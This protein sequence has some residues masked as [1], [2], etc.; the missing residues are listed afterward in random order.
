MSGGV[1][2]EAV[3]ARQ[4][5]RW[6]GWVRLAADIGTL[7]CA[8]VLV[9]FV[10]AAPTSWFERLNPWRRRTTGEAAREEPVRPAPA[11]V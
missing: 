1:V 6:R 5:V 11:E 2:A 10:L 8:L 4:H 7:L 9:L 3:T